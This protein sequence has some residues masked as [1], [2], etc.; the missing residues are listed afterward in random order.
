MTPIEPCRY[1]ETFLDFIEKNPTWLK[2]N[3]ALSTSE[4]TSSL[5]NMLR[6]VYGLY[7]I[8]GETEGEEKEFLLEDFNEFKDYY[9]ELLDNYTKKFNFETGISNSSTSNYNHESNDNASNTNMHVELPN[10]KISNNIFDYPDNA[11]K[12][13]ND[14][15]ITSEDNKV[16]TSVSNDKYITLKNEYIKQIRNVYKEM[17]DRFKD[18]FIMIYS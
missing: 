9:E 13:T 11:D 4:R 18:C 14:K 15:K 3:L 12:E 7:E 1:T 5:T 8:A 16:T 2:E 17:C 6:Y 10:K